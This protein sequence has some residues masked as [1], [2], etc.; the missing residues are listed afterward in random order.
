M[1]VKSTSKQ[2]AVV[3]YAAPRADLTASAGWTGH[4]DGRAV[5]S[6]ERPRDVVD[7][8]EGHRIE[9]ARQPLV[10]VEPQ[11]EEVGRWRN[12]A[13]PPLVS[14]MRGIDPIR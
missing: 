7:V 9:E 1:S 8:V 5:G 3:T 14:S 13:M 12:P 6:Q 4:D 10:E 2:T 11:A